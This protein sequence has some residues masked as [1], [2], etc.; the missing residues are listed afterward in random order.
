MVRPND[1]FTFTRPKKEFFCD[2][3]KVYPHEGA[4][5]I[6]QHSFPFTY[7]L[8]PSLPGT[9]NEKGGHWKNGTG[10]V[11]EVFYFAQAKIDV[12]FKHDLKRKVPLV[13]N[14]RFD[15]FVQ[16]SYGENHK[17]FLLTKGRLHAKVWLDKNVYFPGNTVI[18]RL[19]ANNTSV[20]PTNRV[21]VKVIKHLT[22]HADG[23]TKSHRNEIY[24]QQY[25]GF[26][27]SFYGV[28]WLPF[29]IP[30]D[31][32]PS[33]TTGKHVKCHYYF[34]VECDIP[35]A[36]DLQVE[37]P[38]AILAP[39]WLFS[40]HPQAPP[41]AVLPPD[42]SFRPP[43]QPDNT[44]SGCT[45]CNMTFSLFKR[46]HH[47]RHCGKI[48]CDKCTVRQTKIPNLGYNDE[49]VR[50]CDDCHPTA[51]SGGHTFQQAAVLE[52]APAQEYIPPNYT[53]NENEMPTA[54]PA[55][56]E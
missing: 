2:H 54:P 30:V 37:L 21:N 28:K 23:H 48:F 50:V 46:R 24:R 15:Q 36:I 43:W 29:L 47:C 38:T 45:K 56:K 34:I 13:I 16:P 11:A 12:K 35:G 8:P 31:I 22:L 27:P 19:E 40:Q 39:Q 33:T 17:S 51:T 26:E 53:F 49:P 55:W 20:K 41:P 25:H 10:Y 52:V 5:P 7:Q 1:T 9:F 6:G 32:Q 18:A 14:E 4:V 42:C 3:I 44:T